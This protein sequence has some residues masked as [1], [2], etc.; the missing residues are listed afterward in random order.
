MYA[1]H[2]ISRF[3]SATSRRE[4][5]GQYGGRQRGRGI[6]VKVGAKQGSQLLDCGLD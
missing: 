2:I 1:R 5:L 4:Y 6:F 3:L